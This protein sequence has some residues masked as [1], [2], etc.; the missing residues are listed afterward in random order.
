MAWSGAVVTLGLVTAVVLVASHEAGL[1]TA[2][3]RDAMSA[4]AAIDAALD[5]LVEIETASFAYAM[6]GDARYRAPLAAALDRA[7]AALDR[8]S[9]ELAAEGF[10]AAEIDELERR[11]EACSTHAQRT[12]ELVDAGR[13]DEASAHVREGDRARLG[14]V[15][16]A[17]AR[18]DAEQEARV[19]AHVDASD[20]WATRSTVAMVL[21]LLLA[22]A[23]VVAA[24]VR[25]ARALAALDHAEGALAESER[26]FRNTLENASDLV[27]IFGKRGDLVF[28]SPS[29]ERLLGWTPKEVLAMPDAAEILP[30]PDR[31]RLD[32]IVR[33]FL[34]RG[35]SPPPL[36]HRMLTKAGR[37]RW[38]ETRIDPLF[39]AERQPDGFQS[40]ARDV[41]ARV[42]TER[43]LRLR[44]EEL[45]REAEELRVRSEIDPLTGLFNRAGF[46]ERGEALLRANLEAGRGCAIHFC[47]LDG[48]KA[49]NDELG[50]GD[51]DRAIADAAVV[52]RATARSSDVLA[53]LGGDELVVLAPGS[54]DEGARAFEARLHQESARHNTSADR[55]YVLA[56]SVGHAIAVAG[57]AVSLAEIVAR[58]DEVMYEAKRARRVVRGS[59][60]GIIRR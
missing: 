26:R 11:F 51:G 2:R 12:M 60:E 16:D 13:R 48:L 29:V 46:F 3:A 50:H 27:R 17:M 35:E 44:A 10:G 57:E 37:K 6:T 49:I 31:E 18:L 28:V 20:R 22:L 1:A 55:R 15:H 32:E 34:E 42:A 40:V 7:A 25:A 45:A 43:E 58:A 8:A 36:V 38:F 24:P 5:V 39:D 21:G 54:G 52:L 30:S 56:I 59:L 9:E 33:G 47:D 4:R 23:L 14:A 41:T 53:R 19:A